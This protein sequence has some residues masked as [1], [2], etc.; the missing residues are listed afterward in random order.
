[1]SKILI[2]LE[3]PAINEK[4]DLF[5]P[6]FITIEE[7]TT[8]LSKAI[9]DMTQKQY[10]S[11]GKEVLLYHGYGTENCVILDKKYTVSDYGFKNGDLLYIF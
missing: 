3:V 9:S 8:L 1:M 6:D 11:S 5:I 2:A 7:C 10:V 4:Y